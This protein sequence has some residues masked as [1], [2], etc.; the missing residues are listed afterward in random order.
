MSQKYLRIRSNQDE[1]I[2]RTST[3]KLLDLD[4]PEGNYDFSKSYV[5]LFTRIDTTDGHNN[6]V[7]NV[8][9]QISDGEFDNLS[10][11]NVALI[12]HADLH[13]SN[14]GMV[15]SIRD[16]N[17]LRLLLESTGTNSA[18]RLA[19]LGKDGAIAQVKSR[20]GT[21][22]NF[23]DFGTISGTGEEAIKK[24]EEIQVPLSDILNVGKMNNVDCSSSFLGSC[25]LHLEIDNT[26]LNAVD[27]F[28]GTQAVYTN[29]TANQLGYGLI[30]QVNVAGNVNTVTLTRKYLDDGLSMIPFY[31]GQL[32]S[33][34]GVHSVNGA[35]NTD[36]LTITQVSKTGDDITIT[37][38]NVIDVLG[39]GENLEGALIPKPSVSK[40]PIIEKAELILY[41]NVGVKGDGMGM[42]FTTYSQERDNGNA[43]TNFSRQYQME[44]NAVNMLVHLSNVAN[45]LLSTTRPE[46]YRVSINNEETSNRNIFRHTSLYNHKLLK[47]GLNSNS[48]IVNLTQGYKRSVVNTFD[49]TR[50][51]IIE[52]IYEPLPA[53]GEMNLVNLEIN[54]TSG[55]RDVN[56]FK[57]IVKEIK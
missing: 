5:S 29:A 1:E 39:A 8:G 38:D 43:N 33:F 16:V 10:L 26:R 15:E 52:A 35:V 31:K 40:T 7:M 54:A 27:S 30:N 51:N 55:I 34:T 24:T 25:R 46:S 14:K 47:W 20:W 57:E 6:S 19:R 44:S 22:S 36:N 2:S 13:S 4:I 11:P 3:A 12:K 50:Q 18:E 32:V 48:K 49:S 41:E 37:V 21:Y 28:T 23:V 17:K 45:G 56:I 53:T 9:L 42:S